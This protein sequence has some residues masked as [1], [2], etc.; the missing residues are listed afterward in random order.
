MH[1]TLLLNAGFEPLRIVSWQRAFTLIF[2]GK[3]EILEEYVTTV[4]TV[5][6]SFRVPAVIRLRRWVNLKRQTPVIRFSRANIYARDDHRCQYCQ[7][8][9]SERELTLDHVVPVVRGGKKTWENIVAACIRCNQRK[10]DRTPEEVGLK[11][12]RRPAMPH[13]LPG[14]IG[15]VRTTAA[16]DLWEPYLAIGWQ[17]L[18]S[19]M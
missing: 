4:H 8:R 6:R 9:F 18:K 5:S 19:V 11:L 15:T 17:N 10:G 16:P 13:W 14:L 12:L 1:S 7:Q 3:V 2:Q